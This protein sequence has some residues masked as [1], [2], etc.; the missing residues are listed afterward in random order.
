M[1]ISAIVQVASMHLS[2]SPPV[3]QVHGLGIGPNPALMRALP[4]VTPALV[5]R[6]PAAF[7]AAPG[8]GL[9]RSTALAGFAILRGRSILT[10]AL[11]L[12]L[13]FAPVVHLHHAET[14]SILSDVYQNTMIYDHDWHN[15][16]QP[17]D[18]AQSHA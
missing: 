6:L 1:N 3:I 4:A 12:L 2:P 8:L 13:T 15:H 9:L 17:S 14:A 11:A 18:E 7:A 10:A 16:Q 5:R